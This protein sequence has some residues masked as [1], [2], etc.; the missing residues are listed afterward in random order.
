MLNLQPLVARF[1][2]DVLRALRGASLDDLRDLLA[3]ER[4]APLRPPQ[5]RVS[6]VRREPTRRSARP[7]PA[8][9]K[10]ATAPSSE[11]TAPVVDVAEPAP[12]PP[13]VAEITDPEGLLAGAPTLERAP[14]PAHG[15]PQAAAEP[16]PPPSAARPTVSPTAA[17]REGESLAR[18]AGV[19]LVIRRAK[20]A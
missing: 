12:E 2:D 20:R 14:T 3:P 11:P 5:R 9:R 16:E 18:A 10:A 6:V 13:V 15:A 19:G 8:K 17:L 1:V 4:D 7:R